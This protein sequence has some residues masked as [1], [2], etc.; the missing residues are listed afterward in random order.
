[1]S[2]I[3]DPDFRKELYKNLV[4][5]GYE[6]A[7]AQKIVG[8]KYHKALKDDVTQTVDSFLN[9]I[10]KENYDTSLNYEDVHSKLGELKNLQQVLNAQEQA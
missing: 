4:E 6:K 5:A 3:L 7:E 8:V 9:D 2:K 1:M 10:V